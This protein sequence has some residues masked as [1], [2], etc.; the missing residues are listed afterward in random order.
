[1][2]ND[3]P[4]T[5]RPLDYIAYAPFACVLW[6]LG[7]LPFAWRSWFGGWV[8]RG[9]SGRWIGYRKR[10]MRNLQTVMPN[11]SGEHRQIADAT[12]TNAGRTFLENLYPDDFYA[13]HPHIH[14]WGDGLEALLNAHHSGQSVQLVSGH[15]GNH[16]AMRAALYRHGIRVGGMYKPMSSPLFNRRYETSLQVGGRGGTAFAIGRDGT[17]A[18]RSALCAGNAYLI[19]LIDIAVRSGETIPFLGKPAYTSTAAAAF[20]LNA[21]VPYIPYFSM[22]DGEGFSVEIAAPIP[23]SD[24]LTMTTQ[25]TA[26]LED[27]IQKDPGNWF[28]VH[29]RWKT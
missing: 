3:S 4:R 20:A 25:A 19:L 29:N 6:G 12:L 14:L 26:L 9:P 2:A 21:G 17:R 18:Y 7:L 16:E 5:I 23:P 1:M 13:A 8:L 10:V 22:R 15:F 28:W 27:R 11:R 24:P